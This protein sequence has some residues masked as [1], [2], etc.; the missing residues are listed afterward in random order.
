MLLHGLPLTV[1][2]ALFVSGCYCDHSEHAVS[3]LE[4]DVS[5]LTNVFQDSRRNIRVAMEKLK[6]GIAGIVQAQDEQVAILD[7]LRYA[8]VEMTELLTIVDDAQS[9]LD[10]LDGEVTVSAW[11]GGSGIPS[12]IAAHL[13][14]DQEDTTKVIVEQIGVLS[15]ELSSASKMIEEDWLV[16]RKCFKSNKAPGEEWQRSRICRAAEAN[17]PE[18][19]AQLYGLGYRDDGVFTTRLGTRFVET[20]C[21]MA[22]GGWNVILKTRSRLIVSHQQSS[23]LSPLLHF[24]GNVQ[25]EFWWGL[26]NVLSLVSHKDFELTIR[27]PESTVTFDAFAANQEANHYVFKLGHG[28]ETTTRKL[29]I[30]EGGLR[31]EKVREDAVETEQTLC[32]NAITHVYYLGSETVTLDV[33]CLVVALAGQWVNSSDIVV[34][35]R[36]REA[37]F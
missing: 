34:L 10:N 33:T 4:E 36:P 29:V 11:F 20:Y 16:K 24:L 8:I 30:E 7:R 23:R 6:N 5:Y 28:D 14:E 21:D 32:P 31:V 35:A 17:V 1:G 12:D 9:V 25:D 26:H 22:N 15:A 27:L 37:S 2:V 18:N 3:Q 13:D 19:C